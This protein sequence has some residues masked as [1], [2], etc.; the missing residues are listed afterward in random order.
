VKILVIG[1]G[2]SGVHFALSAL[3]K[4]HDVTMLDVG[5]QGAPIPLP[6]ES[7]VGLKQRMD[8]P[9][10]YFLGDGYAAA[11]LPDSAA[12]LDYYNLPAAKDYVFKTP[13]YL[14]YTAHGISPLVSFAGGGLAQ[15]WT[16]GCYPL[17]DTE[18][19]AFPFS[20]EDIQPYYDEVAR[21]IGIG[22]E[23][24][25][26]GPFFP[27]HEHLLAPVDL[28]ESS[29]IL[30]ARYEGR[31]RKLTAKHGVRM[32]RSRQ[33]ALAQNKDGRGACRY[34][35][36][37]LWGCPNGA[38]YTP[39]FTL[40]ECA[41]YTNFTYR[42]GFFA[43]HFI[44]SR[45][46]LIAEVVAYRLSG[47]PHETFQAD[48]YVLA[49]GT[50]C[51]SNLVLRSVYRSTG[52]IIRLNGLTENRQVLAPFF[53]FGMLGRT[54]NPD[55]YQ[56]HQLAI[57]MFSENS[58]QYVHGQI[59][60]LKTASIHPIVQNLPLGLR[61]AIDVFSNLRSGFGVLNLNFC[62][63]RRE[64][65][66][67][68]LKKSFSGGAE[69]EWPELF[70]YYSPPA[71]E[72]ATMKAALGKA[73]RFFFD[74]GAPIIPG[75]TR[76]RPMGSSVH[77]SGTLPMAREKASWC[78]SGVCQSYDIQNMFVVDGAAMPFLPAKNLTFTLMA[79]AVRVADKLC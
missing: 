20:Y 70:I 62:D 19:S 22:G 24:D 10:S 74:L 33:A 54:L 46:F 39:T 67:L 13:A 63:W 65:N 3:R 6:E 71:G 48:A 61:S 47:G 55:T 4:N 23:D 7:F 41:S 11:V 34:C 31:R 30:L 14:R 58:G 60:T 38:L 2:P 17:N 77:Y 59:T 35:G 56:Y 42:A 43:S 29:A 15:A 21:R 52:E 75:I 8:D 25:D 66:H 69:K 57:G 68:T 79:N 49:C 76:V 44:L 78:L 40:R 45:D 53:N 37:C 1:S 9:V 32:G 28:D 26:L 51:T 36:R 18:L 16:G 5:I 64:E 27:R 50:I 12:R 73:R 72:L